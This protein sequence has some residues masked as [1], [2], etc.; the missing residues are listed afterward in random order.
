MRR[1][2]ENPNLHL[3]YGDSF[4]GMQLMAEKGPFIVVAIETIP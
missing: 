3:Y 2:P 4:N 1:H